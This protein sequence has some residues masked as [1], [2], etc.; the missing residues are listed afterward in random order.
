MRLG[1]AAFGL[2]RG[3]S[4]PR[5]T[6]PPP[7]HCYSLDL[8]QSADSRGW[9]LFVAACLYAPGRKRNPLGGESR[10]RTV[11]K[12]PPNEPHLAF[13]VPGDLATPT[14]GY[15]YDRRII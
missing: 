10:I 1:F 2:L 9:I 13:A 4:F 14:G 8:M 5:E 11:R 3:R 7:L 15:G 6:C 12:S